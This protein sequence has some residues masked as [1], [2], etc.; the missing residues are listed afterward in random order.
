MRNESTE[1]LTKKCLLNA[2]RVLKNMSI[3]IETQKHQKGQAQF[4]SL[5]YRVK[6]FL[7]GKYGNKSLCFKF[8]DTEPTRPDSKMGEYRQEGMPLKLQDRSIQSDPNSTDNFE[9]RERRLIFRFI[10]AAW[11]RQPI[12]IA[13]L[14]YSICKVTVWGSNCPF[15]WKA[16]A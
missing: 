11:P 8:C 4:S 7:E 1:E 3:I 6:H 15:R 16:R 10:K 5:E 9:I 2:Y 14:N 12:F 13:Q